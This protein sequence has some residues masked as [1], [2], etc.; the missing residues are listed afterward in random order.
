[1]IPPLLHPG[2]ILTAQV[3]ALLAPPLFIARR[4]N[5]GRP[6][7]DVY[8]WSAILGLAAQAT[9]GMLWDHFICRAPSLEAGIL[10][11]GWLLASLLCL[12][13]CPAPALGPSP[14][15]ISFR[16]GCLLSAILLATVTLRS[17]HPSQ[18]WALGQSDAYSHLQFIQNVA[19]QGFIAN[20][21]YPPGHTWI[22]VLP[23]VA[24]NLDPYFVARYGGA[25]WGGL[26][27][28]AVYVLLR[29]S[30]TSGTAPLW[31]AFLAGCF[32][33]FNLLHKTAVGV[34]ANQMGLFLVPVVLYFTLEWARHTYRW[35]LPALGLVLSLIA[36][37]ISVPMMV[38]HLAF[39]LGLERLIA[40]VRRE[41][42][43]WVGIRR[44]L[45]ASLPA[46]IV[47]AIHFSRAD[48]SLTVTTL[49]ALS[50]KPAGT[51]S[52]L[53]A[54]VS[55][56]PA[57]PSAVTDTI[58]DYLTVK[59]IGY[60]QPAMDM[61]HIILFLLFAGCVAY[62]IR[63]QSP[64]I[65]LVGL[66]GGLTALQSYT[67]IFQLSK[68]QREGWSLLIATT[69]LGGILGGALYQRVRNWQGIRYVIV[70]G[71][72]A[73]LYVAAIRPPAH[74]LF[75]SPSED[76]L[77]YWIKA[78]AAYYAPSPQW[79]SASSAHSALPNAFRALTPA[80][81]PLLVVRRI[82]GHDSGQGEL[83][84]VVGH[85]M[86]VIALNPIPGSEALFVPGH[87]YIFLM[88]TLPETDTLTD[89][90]TS[91]LQQLSPE[92][93]ETFRYVR[94]GGRL[95]NRWIENFLASQTSRSWDIQRLP[96]SPRLSAVILTPR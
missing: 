13:R 92:M 94:Q 35:T 77:V 38:F 58:K 4:L 11:G 15:G 73:T 80:M 87:S 81:H 24:F 60:H 33:A 16:E 54:A 59:R 49:S 96:L 30:A 69:V 84:V 74:T 12:W 93:A 71:I 57:I 52:T 65:L 63:Q 8:L 91:V 40:I 22:M 61:I 72:I 41:K 14:A 7:P 39:I 75:S 46:L 78:L 43:A 34:F 9:L 51:P 48:S 29:R 5:P 10:I 88:E 50:E 42:N 31:G 68:Y 3:L 28:L 2:L 79:A 76:D 66:W 32:P 85:R 70:A 86:P 44:M 21:I 20:R 37:S 47:L 55:P 23:V 19:D 67:G 27:A 53:V 26:L 17:I 36:L 82:V 1:M 6:W 25:L 89:S 90:D 64:L 56:A 62:G 18:H 83:A 95:A 45:L